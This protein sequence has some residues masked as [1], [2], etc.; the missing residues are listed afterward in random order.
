[1]N[2]PLG[3]RPPADTPRGVPWDCPPR[4]L[5]PRWYRNLLPDMRS[6]ANIHAENSAVRSA[7]LDPFESLN[8]LRCISLPLRA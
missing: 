8:S 5:L 1:M 2:Q 7:E 4:P 3:G 6:P